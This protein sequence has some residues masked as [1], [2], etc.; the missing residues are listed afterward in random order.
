MIAGVSLVGLLSVGFLGVVLLYPQLGEWAIR[1]K[2]VPRLEAKLGRSVQ[3][4]RIQVKRGSAVLEDLSVAGAAE[5][6]PPLVH[7]ARMHVTFDF[8]KTLRGDIDV[9]QAIVERARIHAMRREDGSDDL[10][11]MAE[12]LGFRRVS[13][14]PDRAGR[15]SGLGRL[16]PDVVVV[17]NASLTLIDRAAGVTVE[18][19]AIDTEIPRSGQVELRV[20][21]ASGRTSFGPSAE[22]AA[23]RVTTLLEDPV[24]SARVQVY[25]GALSAVGDISLSSIDGSIESTAEPGALKIGLAGSYGGASEVLWQA[26]GT[27]APKARTG[28]LHLEAERFALGRLASVLTGSALVDFDE[29]EIGARVDLTL[30]DG[31]VTFSG[32][33]EVE[34]AHVYHP[35]LAEKPVRD[36]DMNGEV[37]GRLDTGARQLDIERARMV[38]REVEYR[39]QGAL[40]MPGGIEPETGVRRDKARVEMH[41]SIPPV[42]CRKML[43]G[44]PRELVKYLQG[45]RLA[46]RFSTDLRFAIDWADLDA[47]QLKG[48]VGIHKCRV[49]SEP[50]GDHGLDRLQESFT[51]YVEVAVERWINF[52]IGP[53]NP[54]F[55]PL[56]DVSPHLINSLMSTEDSRFYEHDGFIVREFKSALIKN[57]KAGYFRY[58]AS[59]ITMQ[60]VKNVILYREKTLSRKLQE[61]FFTWHIENKLEKD[62][63]FEIYINA[64]EFGP[65]IYGIGPATRHYF[66]KHPRDLNPV[67]SAFFSSILPNPKKRYQQFCDNKLW[68]W[69]EKKIRRIIK[70]M[71]KRERLT[72]EELEEALAT[73]LVFDRT[74]APTRWEC[75]KLIKEAIENAR[76]TSPMKVTRSRPPGSKK[77]VRR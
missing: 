23:L 77:G 66:G 53:E 59:S 34:N 32:G 50:L 29:T 67:E 54:D 45:F 40:A 27:L 19:G 15:A 60:M 49:I 57:L 20:T 64:I 39:M 3:V 1:N 2:V 56:W 5:G 44:I 74:E 16:R 9:A 47:T 71:H 73:E 52:V 28:K 33:F 22:A 7:I 58:G 68:R 61:L 14:G 69:A 4:G 55:V 48:F 21:D 51:H 62:R 18:L 10:R 38:S 75:K 42:P 24:A 11:D 25:D 36:I 12:R 17:D 13:S 46:G 37:T 72:D 41:V 6:E 8:W 43:A 26:R 70:L 30:R 76:P 35:M 65:G 31:V 63:I